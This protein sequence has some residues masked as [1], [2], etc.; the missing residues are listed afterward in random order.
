MT[1][2][3]VERFV[4]LAFLLFSGVYVAG[5][6][7]LPMGSVRRAGPGFVP[8]MIGIFLA[9]VSLVYGIQVFRETK[10]AEEKRKVLGPGK[11]NFRVGAVISLFALYSVA[12]V[13][14]GFSLSSILLLLILLSLFGMR[15]GKKIVVISILM[16]GGAYFLFVAILGLPLPRG[17]FPF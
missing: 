8:L 6:L 5:A 4:A 15:G 9:G 17:L 3:R 14:L 12:L 7:S 11:E 16:A 10:P 2:R 1:F 13:S